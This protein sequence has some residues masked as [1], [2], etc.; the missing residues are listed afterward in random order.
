MRMRTPFVLCL[1]ATI[2]A[3]LVAQKL[4]VDTMP[5]AAPARHDHRHHDDDDDGNGLRL[6]DQG[7]FGGQL[8]V[9]AEALSWTR[10]IETHGLESRE[11]GLAA[12]LFHSDLEDYYEERA[13]GAGEASIT[14]VT[15]AI[16]NAIFDA[17][18]ARLRQ[19]PF[20]PARVKAA[21]D[22]RT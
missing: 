19:V 15:A 16:G 6:G 5:G 10:P 11:P 14:V 8:H 12:L 7:L 22:A 2:P 1:L 18:G 3:P 13:C 20:T 21:L 9:G 4:D 17:T